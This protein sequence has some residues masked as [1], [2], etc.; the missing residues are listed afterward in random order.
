VRAPLGAPR[1][2]WLQ[3]CFSQ[4]GLLRHRGRQASKHSSHT[5]MRGGQGYGRLGGI[6]AAEAADLH[7]R[8]GA[9][10]AFAAAW[11]LADR[12]GD[13]RL[14]GPEFC[15]FMYLLKAVRRG[16]ALP[17]APLTP[18]QVGRILGPPPPP[19]AGSP[20]PRPAE[21]AAGG[22]LGAG[23]SEEGAG[24]GAGPGWESGWERAGVGGG[25]AAAPALGELLDRG[26]AL[27]DAL[28]RPRS[29]APCLAPNARCGSAGLHSDMRCVVRCK[30]CRPGR[31][32]HALASHA[33]GAAAV[34][35]D[36]QPC[37]V[38][39]SARAAPGPV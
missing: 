33:S 7:A 21:R 23:S 20:P 14:A 2:V 3:G 17:G 13:G 30:R 4:L 15:L 8:S 34:T 37:P 26:W 1:R 38:L 16:L 31:L 24:S 10:G 27:P 36:S 32:S 25:G 12:D 11:R 18:A 28:V 39:R 6:G 19:A 9:R 5:H 22:G 35:A 29:A